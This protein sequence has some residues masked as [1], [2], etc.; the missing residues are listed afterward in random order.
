VRNVRQIDDK[1]HGTTH[2][3]S[4]VTTLNCEASATLRG[5]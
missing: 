5:G 2:Q 4:G 1:P 3:A